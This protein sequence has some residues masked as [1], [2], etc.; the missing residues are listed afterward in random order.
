MDAPLP[1]RLM[2]EVPSRNVLGVRG[3]GEPHRPQ[4]LQG[5]LF[6]RVLFTRVPRRRV[7][8][9][10]YTGSRIAT[11]LRDRLKKPPTADYAASYGEQELSERP[12]RP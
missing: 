6:T 1:D 3:S 9:S 11:S 7:L 5:G 2:A 10:P 4:T 8:G 12:Y